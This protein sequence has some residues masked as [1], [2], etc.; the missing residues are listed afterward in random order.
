MFSGTI[1]IIKVTSAKRRMPSSLILPSTCKRPRESRGMP[2]GFRLSSN[3]SE[4]NIGIRKCQPRLPSRISQRSKNPRIALCRGQECWGEHCFEP[5]MSCLAL[6]LNRRQHARAY[7]DLTESEIQEVLQ[8]S[9]TR[10]PRT[11]AHR[12]QLGK[13]SSEVRQE[14]AGII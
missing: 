14:G 13:L 12:G 7:L 9:T 3:W 1:C 6:A 8:G 5:V 11:D 4:R 2:S 10:S